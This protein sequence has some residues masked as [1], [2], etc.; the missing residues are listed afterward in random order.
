MDPFA[1]LAANRQDSLTGG[2]PELSVRAIARACR[3]ALTFAEG[4]TEADF[5]ADSKLRHA[6]SL[7]LVIIGDAAGRLT[8][9]HPE[10]AR[11]Q[12]S[13]PWGRLARMPNRIIRDCSRLN[14]SLVWNTV[15]NDL[16]P[17]LGQLEPI[18]AN[19]PEPDPS[20]S[21]NTTR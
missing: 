16:E 18:L 4:A 1:A 2:A 6:V 21:T 9:D 19:L 13:I 5:L 20:S 8:R 15:T 12:A 11:E 14:S 17:L 7:N 10:F 3:K